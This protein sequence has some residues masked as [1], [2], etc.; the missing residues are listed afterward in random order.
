M[1]NSGASMSSTNTEYSEQKGYKKI[2]RI[3]TVKNLHPAYKNYHIQRGEEIEANT[4]GRSKQSSQDTNPIPIIN[5]NNQIAYPPPVEKI[6]VSRRSPNPTKRLK[7]R[8][9]FSEFYPRYQ[10]LW[11]G[12]K[13]EN[14]KYEVEVSVGSWAVIGEGETIK[15]AKNQAAI[16]MLHMT[17][18]YQKKPGRQP[19]FEKTVSP[20]NR[21][22]KAI[23]RQ[24]STT[25]RRQ[26]LGTPVY[27]KIDQT[28]GNKK[29]GR[30]VICCAGDKAA[31][32]VGADLEKAVIAAA[33]RMTDSLNEVE[34]DSR[35]QNLETITLIG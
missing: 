6:T 34:Y 18:I 33:K 4:E 17:N 5:G 19:F 1:M 29:V 14:G 32:G 27:T 24:V 9:R 22:G 30:I 21:T 26:N 35:G 31:T 20:D 16:T 13:S 3:T 2:A 12:K 11:G 7:Y 25:C 23:L 28:E 15:E 8:F 10:A